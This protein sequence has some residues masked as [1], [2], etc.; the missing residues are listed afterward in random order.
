MC[1]I[2]MQ[3]D[4]TAYRC[5]KHSFDDVPPTHGLAYE[6]L[7][8]LRYTSKALASNIHWSLYDLLAQRY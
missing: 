4:H 2:R 1:Y 6:L 5:F 7:L 8:S 3:K